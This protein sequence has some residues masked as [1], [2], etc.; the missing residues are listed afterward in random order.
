MASYRMRYRAT[1]TKTGEVVEGNSQEMIDRFHIA[2][3]N[4]YQYSSTGQLFNYQWIFSRICDE[5]VESNCKIHKAKL[6][7]LAEWDRVTEPFKE[8]A[9]RRKEQI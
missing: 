4:L 3:N 6:A 8:L 7:K 2:R 9:R 5:K 1:N